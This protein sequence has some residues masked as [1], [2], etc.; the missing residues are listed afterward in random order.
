MEKAARKYS[1]C[2]VVKEGLWILKANKGKGGETEYTI[3]K[4]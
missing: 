1:R 3:K 4:R 2:P